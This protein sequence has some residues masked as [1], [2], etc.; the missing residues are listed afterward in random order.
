MKKRQDSRIL[1]FHS[2]EEEREH[3]EAR[4]PLAEGRKGKVSRPRPGQK[5]SSFLAVRMTGEELTRLREVA[6]KQGMGPSTFAR[7]V[8]TEAIEERSAPLGTNTLGDVMEAIEGNLPERMKQRMEAVL[9][10]VSMGE[11]PFLLELTHRKKLEDFAHLTMAAFLSMAGAKVIVP[12]KERRKGA[13]DVA[14]KRS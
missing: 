6:E 11:A 10:A 5:R 12:E 4:G 14:R 2:P 3:W 13:A 8:L 7:H 9:K 1:E